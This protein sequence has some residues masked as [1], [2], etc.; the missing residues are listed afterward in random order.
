LPANLDPD[1]R[2]AV[3]DTAGPVPASCRAALKVAYERGLI[4]P[5]RR[6]RVGRGQDSK[7]PGS[8][9]DLAALR[10]AQIQMQNSKT[11]LNRYKKFCVKKIPR[12]PQISSFA[13]LKPLATRPITN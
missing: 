6:H 11:Q 9:S 12:P 3:L 1:R 7:A 10:L 5:H 8:H 4:A 13:L 2:H